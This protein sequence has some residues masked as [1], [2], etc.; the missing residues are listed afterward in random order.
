M[1]TPEYFR[2]MHIRL[3][4]GRGFTPDDR[5]G[6]PAVGVISQALA[7]LSFPERNPVGQQLLVKDNPDG[8]R[9]IEIVGVVGDVRHA[10]LEGAAEPHLYVPYHQTHAS[11]LVWLAQTQFVVVRTA[12]A[13]LSL[14]PLVRRAVQAVDPNVATAGPRLTGDY[15]ETAAAGRRFSLLL[16]SLFAGVA[17]ALATVGIYGVVSYSVDRRTRETGLRRAL[18]ASTI[19]VVGLVLGHGLR[20]AAAGIAVGLLAAL[21]TARALRGL[22]F[23]VDAADP[24]TY[25]AVV[26]VLLAVTV[27]A[28]LLPAWRAARL[29]PV[30]ALRRD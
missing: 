18:G 7:R 6:R 5:A 28:C 29:D 10:S 27:A 25:A 26:A 23:G 22:L 16:L 2:A 1:A 19:A 17:L 15:V 20:H 12:S 13:P 21:L 4:A 11:L 8:F 24:A 30:E 9:P 14:G 3:L